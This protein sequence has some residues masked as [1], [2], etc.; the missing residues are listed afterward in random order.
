MQT[1]RAPRFQR[2]LTF[3]IAFTL[4]FVG[5]CIYKYLVGVFEGHWPHHTPRQLLAHQ[6]ENSPARCVHHARWEPIMESQPVR[7]HH[8]PEGPDQSHAWFM[9]QSDDDLESLLQLSQDKHAPG[10][11]D[12]DRVQSSAAGATADNNIEAEFGVEA[13]GFYESEAEEAPQPNMRTICALRRSQGQYDIVVQ[14]HPCGARDDDTLN[15][16]AEHSHP[17]HVT[18]RIVGRNVHLVQGDVD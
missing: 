16:P 15:D 7:G 13:E 11:V 6:T 10:V 5:L 17:R 1:Q 18:S 8:H 2:I 4:V 14:G 12:C 9:L 3:T